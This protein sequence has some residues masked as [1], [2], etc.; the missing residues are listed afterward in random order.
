M[1]AKKQTSERNTYAARD[2]KES[3]AGR[4][5]RRERRG[6]RAGKRA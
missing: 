3:K 4:L 2:K 5:H 6:I 1:K